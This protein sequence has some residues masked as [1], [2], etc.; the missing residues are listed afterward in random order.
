MVNNLAMTIDTVV[1][2][3]NQKLQTKFIR[4]RNDVENYSCLFLFFFL[5]MQLF[6]IQ[7]ISCYHYVV[8]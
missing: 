8:H 2:L 7:T 3:F 6:T 4:F 5:L 1:L